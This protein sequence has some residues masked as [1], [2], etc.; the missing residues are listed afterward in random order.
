[1][2]RNSDQQQL[3]KTSARR[4][5]LELRLP[6][7]D[8]SALCQGVRI[9]CADL[10]GEGSLNISYSDGIFLLELKIISPAFAALS[11]NWRLDDP[12]GVLYWCKGANSPACSKEMTWILGNQNS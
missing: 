12:L 7:R 8:D 1:M 9:A 10:L 6:C 2:S 5:A 4:E 3:V 11:I